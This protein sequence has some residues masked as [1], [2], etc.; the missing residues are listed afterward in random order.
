[1]SLVRCPGSHSCQGRSRPPRVRAGT[2]PPPRVQVLGPPGTAQSS[3]TA[4]RQ[5]SIR[6]CQLPHVPLSRVASR[7]NPQ[8][9][10]T[11]GDSP[12]PG[13]RQGPT[14]LRTACVTFK[15]HL[16][17]TPC[18]HYTGDLDATPP[19]ANPHA[20]VGLTGHNRLAPWER[21]SVRRPAGQCPGRAAGRRRAGHSGG[22]DCS[23]SPG[24]TQSVCALNLFDPVSLSCTVTG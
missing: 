16:V 10:H 7:G 8:G 9:G 3:C 15:Q 22:T 2:Q 21:L 4:R 19:A 12:R 13:E 24:R 17:L 23:P 6:R 11:P 5:T 14:P 1:M 18:T 20:A